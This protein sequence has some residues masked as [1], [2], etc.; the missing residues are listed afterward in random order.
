[1]LLDM[2]RSTANGEKEL[3]AE[4]DLSPDCG[5]LSDFLQ[6]EQRTYADELR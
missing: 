3:Q 1:M 2:R 4:R 5:G 6:V